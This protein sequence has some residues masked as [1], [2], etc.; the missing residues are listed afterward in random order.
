MIRAVA[1]IKEII[2]KTYAMSEDCVLVLIFPMESI[3]LKGSV[4]YLH[5]P[6]KGI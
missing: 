4:R 5:A 1:K 3:T 6:A 2:D